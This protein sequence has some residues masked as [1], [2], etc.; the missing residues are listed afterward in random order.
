MTHTFRINGNISNAD[1]SEA[2]DT[3]NY[4][5]D[6]FATKIIVVQIIGHNKEL[7][8]I[9]EDTNYNDVIDSITMLLAQYPTRLGDKWQIDYQ[10]FIPVV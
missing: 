7:N 3:L 10:D 8:F 4:F 9:I 6:T 5:K 1:N 2:L